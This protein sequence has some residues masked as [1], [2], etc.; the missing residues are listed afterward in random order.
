M[1]GL[2]NNVNQDSGAL[3]GTLISASNR[4][5]V[6]LN[7]S[8]SEAKD[9]YVAV[10]MTT[11]DRKTIGATT[12]SFEGNKAARWAWADIND[13][14]GERFLGWGEPLVIEEEIGNSNKILKIRVKSEEGESVQSDIS[15]SIRITGVEAPAQ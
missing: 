3:E 13:P 7:S 10:R 14:T 2:Y 8:I 6:T 4:L 11:D 1:I 12:L 15:T 5:T 9:I